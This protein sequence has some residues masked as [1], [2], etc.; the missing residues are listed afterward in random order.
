MASEWFADAESG[1]EVDLGSKWFRAH[2]RLGHDVERKA[3]V[4]PLG[5]GQTESVDRDRVADRWIERALD[6]EPPAVE[7][8]DSPTLSDDAGEH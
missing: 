3:A 7:G 5:D 4:R 6:D 8:S 2:Q 1:L